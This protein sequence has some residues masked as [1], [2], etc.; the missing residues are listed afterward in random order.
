MR[1]EIENL[2][3]S[4]LTG[5]GAAYVNVP[6]V[7]LVYLGK[8]T[9]DSLNASLKDAFKTSFKVKPE[10]CELLI[11]NPKLTV[12]VAQAKMEQTLR[13]AAEQGTDV[14]NLK[15]VFISLMDDEIFKEDCRSLAETLAHAVQHMK[16]L[17]ITVRQPAFYGIFR[18]GNVHQDYT[19]VFGFVNHG[20]NLWK[21]IYHMEIPVFARLEKYAE[22]LVIHSMTEESYQMQQVSDSQE[23]RWKSVYVHSLKVSELLL[24]RILINVYQKQIDGKNVNVIQ[25]SKNVKRELENVFEQLFSMEESG[26][27]QF[28]PLCYPQ[29]MKI[30][31]DERLIDT[32]L[33]D[34]YGDREPESYTQIL[35]NMVSAT[36]SLPSSFADISLKMQGFLE[37]MRQAYESELEQQM[38]SLTMIQE[39]GTT[40]SEM[41]KNIYGRKKQVF[42]LQKK[43]QIIQKLGE[44]LLK[45]DLF[46][47]MVEKIQE[48]NRELVEE[49]MKLVRN[50]YGG[51]L[52]DVALQDGDNASFQINQP[53]GEIFDLIPRQMLVNFVNDD[54]TIQN[55]LTQ[56]IN[57]ILSPENLGKGHNLGEINGIYANIA[58]IS[59]VM[60]C[61]TMQSNDPNIAALVQHFS[62]LV[63]QGNDL[64]KKNEFHFITTREYESDGYIVRYKRG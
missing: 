61:Q 47:G 50:E 15:M 52:V 46:S 12:D 42:I 33:K 59:P 4:L 1:A 17:G 35:K 37:T 60:V 36:S 44:E 9:Y 19:N 10:V 63:L 2:C 43:L 23:Y 58:T 40:F 45:D 51:I 64:M 49:L 24:A 54:Y 62:E 14:Y 25:W 18:R 30:L 16:E 11:E 6:T 21:N 41:L 22:M 48:K 32:L 53:A 34:L 20:K 27:E 13:E 29:D 38:D 7:L 28:L 8:Q 5:E 26:E 57:G 31:Q 3:E 39:R 56:F 55:G